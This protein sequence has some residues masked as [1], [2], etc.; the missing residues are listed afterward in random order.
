M[1]AASGEV[2][3]PYLGLDDTA[4]VRDSGVVAVLTPDE[5][6]ERAQSGWTPLFKPLV[7]GLAPELG[8]ASLE[9][10]AEKVLPRL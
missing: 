8:W 1:A 6:L 4:A 7:A 10:F 3:H 9:L 2:N 5:C